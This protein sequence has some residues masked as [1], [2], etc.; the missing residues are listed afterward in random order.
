MSGQR[1]RI[2]QREVQTIVRGA[3]KAGAK[4]VTVRVGEAEVEISLSTEEQKTVAPEEQ[5]R[6]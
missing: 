5:I 4:A 6:L 2:R 1:A 3:M